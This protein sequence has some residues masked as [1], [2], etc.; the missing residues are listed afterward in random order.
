MIESVLYS[1]TVA[2]P[3]NGA[4]RYV[5]LTKSIAHAF[6]DLPENVEVNC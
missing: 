6:K 1:M 5:G 4:K 3:T 2:T